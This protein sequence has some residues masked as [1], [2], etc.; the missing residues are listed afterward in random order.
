[1]AMEMKQIFK[2]GY[3]VAMQNDANQRAFEGTKTSLQQKAL[4]AFPRLRSRGKL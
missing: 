2:F 3:L 1:M 4:A